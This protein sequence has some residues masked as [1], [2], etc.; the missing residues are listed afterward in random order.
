[1]VNWPDNGSPEKRLSTRKDR[2]NVKIVVKEWQEELDK[3][4]KM[5]RMKEQEIKILFLSVMERII[6]CLNVSSFNKFYLLQLQNEYIVHSIYVLVLSPIYLL[7]L[8]MRN[9]SILIINSERWREFCKCQAN[10]VATSVSG[11][12]LV[13]KQQ[14]K[15][16]NINQFLLSHRFLPIKLHI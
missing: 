7:Y 11:Y 5:S 3:K 6:S 14:R 4:V 13:E 1:M 9:N 8:V 16:K 15:Y 12:S 10:F 2:E